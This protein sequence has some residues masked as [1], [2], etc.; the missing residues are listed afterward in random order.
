M[1]AEADLVNY[2]R[3]L[4]LE[5]EMDNL[6]FD[7]EIEEDLQTLKSSIAKKDEKTTPL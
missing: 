3:K 7:D 5:E 6:V 2:G 1:E 4:P